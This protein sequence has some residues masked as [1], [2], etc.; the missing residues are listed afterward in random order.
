MSPPTQAPLPPYY[1]P[2]SSPRTY[3]SPQ[4]QQY[5]TTSLLPYRYVWIWHMHLYAHRQT[6]TYA[7]ENGR[8]VKGVV[9]TGSEPV[10]GTYDPMEGEGIEGVPRRARTKDQGSR[11]GKVKGGRGKGEE[12]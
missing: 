2:S 11:K 5:F 1:R 6:R 8:E 10:I 9:T 4:E 12:K 7:P 3:P